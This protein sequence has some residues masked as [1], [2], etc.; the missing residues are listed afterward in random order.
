MGE[1]LFKI[2]NK[3]IN[4]SKL[5]RLLKYQD[6]NPLDKEAH[7]EVNG[8][9]LLNKQIL[10][11]PKYPEDGIE[12][13]KVLIVFDNFTVNPANTD[14]KLV[15]IRFDVVCPFT[16]WI[17]NEANLRPYLIM[18]EIDKMF[19]QTKLNGIGNLQ[20]NTA[21]PLILSPQVGGYSMFYSINEFN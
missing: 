13:S 21:T 9:E 4:N 20:F 10:L 3:M 8:V 17:V 5:C 6:A 12:Y 15:R 11:V 1:N 18:E 7:P 16:E 2:A 14:F 19:N